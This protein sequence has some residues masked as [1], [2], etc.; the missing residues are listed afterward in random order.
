LPKENVQLFPNTKFAARNVEE[1][2]RILHNVS[3]L[4]LVD[5]WEIDF[6]IFHLQKD[7]NVLKENSKIIIKL[8]R[9]NL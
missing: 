6:K 3:L 4:Y 9:K 8:I 7:F 5:C 1:E 2:E